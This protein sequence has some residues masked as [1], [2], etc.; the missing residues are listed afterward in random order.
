MIR[1]LKLKKNG[2]GR[3]WQ[4]IKRVDHLPLHKYI[5]TLSEYG[6]TPTEQLLNA[7]RRLEA[8]E[9]ASQSP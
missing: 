7:S 3:R 8:S 5:I 2:D 9:K 4:H 1:D 6:T